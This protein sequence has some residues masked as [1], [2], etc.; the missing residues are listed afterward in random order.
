MVLAP[1]AGEPVHLSPEE[2]A[3]LL[4]AMEDINQGKFVDGDDLLAEL[5][6]GLNR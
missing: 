6:S 2:E 5:R 1:E 3:E 4:K